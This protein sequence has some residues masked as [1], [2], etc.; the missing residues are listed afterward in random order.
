M[1]LMIR[2]CAK[3]F[4]TVIQFVTVNVVRFLASSQRPPELFFQD[5]DVLKNITLSVGA[6]MVRGKDF[7]VSL[8][9]DICLSAIE[10]RAFGRAEVGALSLGPKKP[11]AKQ[12]PPLRD[13]GRMGDPIGIHMLPATEVPVIH[14][15]R[16]LM[17]AETTK[18]AGRIRKAVL[19]TFSMGF[20]FGGGQRPPSL[21]ER[22]AMATAK[23]ASRFLAGSI[24]V[25]QYVGVAI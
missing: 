6:V 22:I 11:T 24:R 13:D 16:M 3:V 5:N 20:F 8:F 17:K 10:A 15:G 4:G 21:P 25:N 12:T 7:F 9:D 23:E 1:S 18:I 2:K 19:P 14:R